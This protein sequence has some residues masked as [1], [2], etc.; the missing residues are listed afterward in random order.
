MVSTICRTCGQ[1]GNYC[2]HDDNE[3]HD[4]YMHSVNEGRREQNALD[5]RRE[6]IAKLVRGDDEN[7]IVQELDRGC[8]ER[9]DQESGYGPGQY[10]LFFHICLVRLDGAGFRVSD[11]PYTRRNE[12]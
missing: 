3:A 10:W 4:D 7:A 1:P 12:R 2:S 5:A 9:G 8:D 6:R 11:D